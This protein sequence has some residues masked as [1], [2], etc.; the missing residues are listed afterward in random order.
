MTRK[1]IAGNWK[2]NGSLADNEAL[3]R[4]VLA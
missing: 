2:M 4:A 3:L 1:L